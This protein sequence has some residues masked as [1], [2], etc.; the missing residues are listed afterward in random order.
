[1]GG[2]LIWSDLRLK[3]KKKRKNF[4]GVS[5]LEKWKPET[6]QQK[7]VLVTYHA[8]FAVYLKLMNIPHH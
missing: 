5:C 8:H 1:M 7:H 2:L 6:T 4:T 3:K